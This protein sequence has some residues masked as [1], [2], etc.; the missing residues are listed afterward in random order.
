MNRVQRWTALWGV[1]TLALLAYGDPGL[2]PPPATTRDRS[3]GAAVLLLMLALWWG[4]IRRA[5]RLPMSPTKRRVLSPSWHAMTALLVF[6]PAFMTVTG[7]FAPRWLDLLGLV[8]L[9]G[10]L[11]VEAGTLTEG[12]VEARVRR[13][14]RALPWVV[15]VVL[16]VWVLTWFVIRRP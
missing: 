13:Y 2:V 9:F 8:G 1:A 11:V 12:E 7:S 14:R 5:R 4:G 15:G 3:V 10:F 16:V 6:S